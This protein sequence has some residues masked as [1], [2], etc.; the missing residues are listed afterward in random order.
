[1]AVDRIEGEADIFIDAI[2]LGAVLIVTADYR[3]LNTDNGFA[4]MGTGKRRSFSFAD[5][6]R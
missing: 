3:P 4:A 5:T 6:A 2:S 1:M